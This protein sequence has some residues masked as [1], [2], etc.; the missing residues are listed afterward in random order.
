MQPNKVYDEVIEFIASSSPQNVI[1]FA[2]SEEA[3]NRIADLIFGKRR[4]VYRMTKKPNLISACRVTLS[5]AW[6]RY[7]LIIIW[8]ECSET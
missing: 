6:Q 4:R 5:C 2:A 1:A 7:G 3:K 8:Q